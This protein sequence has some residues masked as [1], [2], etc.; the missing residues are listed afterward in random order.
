MK[1]QKLIARLQILV[2]GG[3]PRTSD[4]VR[5]RILETPEAEIRELRASLDKLQQEAQPLLDRERQR[6]FEEERM[7]REKVASGLARD[8]Q[9]PP[10]HQMMPGEIWR[11]TLPPEVDLGVLEDALFWWVM[12]VVPRHPRRSS[13]E[14]AWGGPQT[15]SGV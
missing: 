12:E 14:V 4:P 5:N 13:Q 15:P 1:I 2:G 8:L 9:F 7:R 11:V 3:R 10:R 6:R